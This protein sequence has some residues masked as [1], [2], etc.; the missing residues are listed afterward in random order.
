MTTE[1]SVRALMFTVPGRD[2]W[3]RAQLIATGGC[4]RTPHFAVDMR[5]VPSAAPT[6]LRQVTVPSS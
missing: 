3:S 5:R 6:R 2:E 1:C 4:N